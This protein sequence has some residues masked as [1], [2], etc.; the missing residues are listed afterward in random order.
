MSSLSGTG[1]VA[2]EVR[3]RELR[4]AIRSLWPDRDDATVMSELVAL[5]AQLRRV[6]REQGAR[7]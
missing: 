2:V 5:M 3:V 1:P 6:E 4:A 7:T